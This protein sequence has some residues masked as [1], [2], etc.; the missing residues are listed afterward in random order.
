MT[1][2]QLSIFIENREGTLVKV[3]EI[4][5]DAGIQIVASTIADTADY[6]IY[7]MICS[8]PQRAYEELHKAGVSVALS[9]VFA[10]QL[11]NEPGCCCDAVRIISNSG[12]AITYMYTFLLEGKGIM[13]FRADDTEATREVILRNSMPYISEEALKMD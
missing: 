9:D 2:H 5:K 8:E 11:D 10:L 1:I 3:L 4:L 6:G 13:I 12:I 7:R